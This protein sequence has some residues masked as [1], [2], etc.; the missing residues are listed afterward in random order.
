MATPDH[1]VVLTIP[2]PRTV[3]LKEK[4]YPRVA[5]G[6]VLV[7]VRIAPI[8]IEHQIYRDH[9][10]EWHE[11]AEHLGHEGVGE[12]VETAAGSQFSVGD[13][14]VVYQGN[15]CGECFVCEE[16]LNP[17]HCMAIPYEQIS[18][19]GDPHAALE[20][21]GGDSAMN[22]PGGMKSIEVACDSESGGFGFSRYRLA[23][24]RMVQKIPDDLAFR[25]AA[26]ANCS[27]GCTYTPAEE[28]G[29]KKGDW[30]MVA[31][32]GFIGFGAIINAKYRG[33]NVIA[34]GRNA[35]RM[36]LAQK[37]GADHVIN[38]DDDDWL[39]QV[40]A[41]T[42]KQAGCNTV[43]ECS[44]YP[45]YQKRALAACRRYGH[46]YL[47]GFL[48]DDEEPL[49]IALLDEIHNRHVTLTGG[50]DVR[51]KDRPGLVEMLRDSRVQQ[52]ID[53]MVT[54]EFNMSDGAKAFE[55]ALSKKA[56]KIYLYPQED[57]PSA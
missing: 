46:M 52:A 20:A 49:P 54:H 16:K 18:G 27:L 30:V 55:A 12:I 40:H 33:A 14:V 7:R 39:D 44:G 48:V 38:P 42:G 29:V 9:T 10:F 37:L 56:G 26:A 53:N 13:R 50:H 47:L 45:Y 11:D 35:F 36:E 23:P 34:L 41:L 15:P 22:T 43:F 19:A 28:A 2:E 25:Y 57:C 51:V 4:P 17:T 31:G 24:E 8:C 32:I 1:N 3:E 5:P 21:L 6:Y